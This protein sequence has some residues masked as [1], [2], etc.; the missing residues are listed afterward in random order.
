MLQQGYCYF[1]N[2]HMTVP[3]IIASYDSLA[4]D[5]PYWIK[6]ISVAYLIQFTA[7]K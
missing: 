6:K 2:I 4:I 1:G 5:N 3:H 7:S